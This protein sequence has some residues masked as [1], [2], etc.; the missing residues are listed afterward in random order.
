MLIEPR[1]DEAQSVHD[2]VAKREL[3]HECTTVIVN[4]TANMDLKMCP[5]SVANN[6]H[7][8]G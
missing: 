8:Y 4:L 6:P 5:G 7:R 2:S 1:L 3:A